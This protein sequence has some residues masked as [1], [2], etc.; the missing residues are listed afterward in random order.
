MEDSESIL[1]VIAVYQ[2]TV[3]RNGESAK[4]TENSFSVHYFAEFFFR[5]NKNG[6]SNDINMR[7]RNGAH[8]SAILMNVNK[9][10][11]N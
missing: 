7:K 6:F 10:P 8:A 2:E 1:K 9:Q 5:A 3:K 11:N 4:S